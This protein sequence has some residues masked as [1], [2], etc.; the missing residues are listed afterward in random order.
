MAE[1]TIKAFRVTVKDLETGETIADNITP[2]VMIAF[3]EKRKRERGTFH[4]G[5]SQ[6]I[7]GQHTDNAARLRCTQSYEGRHFASHRKK[8]RKGTRS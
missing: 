3:F 8:S 2:L 1:A 6:K 7:H 4:S 5:N